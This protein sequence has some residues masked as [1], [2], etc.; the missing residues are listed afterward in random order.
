[1]E[2]VKEIIFNW[3]FDQEIKEGTFPEL[4][5]IILQPPY[6]ENFNIIYDQN[7]KF[8]G[9]YRKESVTI[10]SNTEFY[11]KKE[12]GYF[13][14]LKKITFGSE[15]DM[16]INPGDLSNV[17][18]IIFP[19]SSKFNQPIRK[20]TFPELKK[21]TFGRF[22]KG[23]IDPEA[24]EKV[25]EIEFNSDKFDQ[26]IKPGTFPNLKKISFG[27]DFNNGGKLFDPLAMP[28]VIEIIFHPFSY[29]DQEIK[30]GTFPNL[31]KIVFGT[32][33]KRDYNIIYDGNNKF[34]KTQK[35][36][37]KRIL[38]TVKKF[39]KSCSRGFCTRRRR[40]NNRT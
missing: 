3:G 30:E 13:K 25:E 23:Q 38:N 14:Y 27:P 11:N 6:Y 32:Y 5:K 36:F 17:E 22:F 39:K 24:M 9:S 20:G 31:E 19:F 34:I 26:E 15:F 12:K 21:I 1:M 28:N 10:E 29:F 8:V 7:G 35:K 33:Y 18:E 40:L 37:K 16:I 4:E 2:K